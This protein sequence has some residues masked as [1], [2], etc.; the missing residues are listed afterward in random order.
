[1]IKNDM[2]L[3]ARY[4][5]IHKEKAAQYSAN[6]IYAVILLVLFLI[7]GAY[8]LKLFLDN[9]MLKGEVN[10]LQAYVESPNVIA[11][12]NE[13]ATLQDNIKKL[14]EMAAEVGSINEVLKTAVRFDSNTL[15]VLFYNRPSNVEFQN[16]SFQQGALLVTVTGPRPSDPS[17]YVLRLQRTDYFKEVTYTGYA[18]DAGSSQY[19]TTIRLVMKGRD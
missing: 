11:R 15:N 4:Q 2:N 13:I 6:K 8:S 17:Y 16:I 1:M 14:D 19:T 12:M 5:E 9:N 10:D 7:I 18:Y 3:L